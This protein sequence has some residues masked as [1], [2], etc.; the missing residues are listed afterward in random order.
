[1]SLLS[2]AFLNLAFP[3]LFFL[4]CFLCFVF[5]AHRLS[6]SNQS[7]LEVLVVQSVVPIAERLGAAGVRQALAVDVS[8]AIAVQVVGDIKRR[9]GMGRMRAGGMVMAGLAHEVRG[10]GVQ[11]REHEAA[12][13]SD[14]FEGRGGD[15]QALGHVIT[16]RRE[17]AGAEVV[18]IAHV[19]GCK[20]R[21]RLGRELA[22]S[23]S[24]LCW[25]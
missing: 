10:G 20:R 23:V 2:R 13:V 21:E 8:R 18:A 1:M 12:R 4:V 3:F 17:E 16:A 5:V 11:R 19:G 22:Q 24:H 6:K 14:V 15:G 9:K 7:R 25:G